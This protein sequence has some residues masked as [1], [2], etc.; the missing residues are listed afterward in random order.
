[1]ERIMKPGINAE[2]ERDTDAGTLS[3]RRITQLRRMIK[4]NISATTSPITIPEIMF[5]PPN[6]FAPTAYASPTL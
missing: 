6:Q 3:G 1:M 2:N 5:A 4:V